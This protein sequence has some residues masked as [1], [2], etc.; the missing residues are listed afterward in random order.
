MD[1]NSYPSS[2]TAAPEMISRNLYRFDTVGLPGEDEMQVFA[3][4]CRSDIIIST[5][6]CS[7]AHSVTGDDV[8]RCL[9][10][11]ED[12]VRMIVTCGFPEIFGCRIEDWEAA[13]PM[14]KRK[15]IYM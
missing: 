1:D 9:P 13:S 3:D 2:I 7:V 4:T 11:M 10:Y 5:S 8:I 12:R 6:R 14:Q 15:R